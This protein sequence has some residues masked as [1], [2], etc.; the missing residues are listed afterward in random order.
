MAVIALVIAGVLLWLSGCVRA[1]LDTNQEVLDEQQGRVTAE[2]LAVDT[3]TLPVAIAIAVANNPDYNSCFLRVD[4]ARM[5][6]YQTLAAYAPGVVLS[7]NIGDT[8]LQ[9]SALKNPPELIVPH[10]NEF[11]TNV[12]LRGSWLLFDGFARELRTL[13]ARTDVAAQKYETLNVKRLLQRAVAYAYWDILLAEANCEI[14]DANLVYQLSNLSQ[15]ESRYIA[16]HISKSS[17]LN[18]KVLHLQAEIQVVQAKEQYQIALYALAVLLGEPSGT[19]PAQVK[20]PRLNEL[21][22]PNLLPVAVYLSTALEWRPDLQKLRQEIE[23]LNY[24]KWSKLSAYLPTVSAYG[25]TGYDTNL[26]NYRGADLNHRGWNSFNVDY[27]ATA[28]WLLFDGLDKYNQYREYKYLEEQAVLNLDAAALRAINEVRIGCETLQTNISL[29]KF[30]QEQLQY[31]TEQRDLVT[32]EYWAG[33]VTITR[34]NEAQNVLVQAQNSLAVSLV[35]TQKSVA[36]LNAA[37]NIDVYLDAEEEGRN[38]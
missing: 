14:A 17:L 34:L 19:I 23:S 4:A 22:P 2:L 18:F 20:F 16:G 7:G 13:A 12:G 29:V 25:G 1:P 27:G 35:D 30:Y 31:V 8:V 36:Q 5:A 33:N 24:Q 15:A 37:V 3:L 9:N 28:S 11:T 26:Y 38:E 10:D 32:V 21:P 6:Y